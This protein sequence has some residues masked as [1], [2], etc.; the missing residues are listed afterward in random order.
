M[1]LDGLS[2]GSKNFYPDWL[3]RKMM[4]TQ[5]TKGKCRNNKMNY[6]F[7]LL[8]FTLECKAGAEF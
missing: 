6:S 1:F 7:T 2:R 5:I 4:T 3:K 8:D